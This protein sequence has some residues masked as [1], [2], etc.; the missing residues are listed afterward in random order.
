MPYG[1]QPPKF[2]QF[3]GKGNPKQH[4]AHFIETCNNAGTNGDLL[5]KRFVRSLKSTA[6]DWYTDLGSES[7]GSWDQ[8]ENEFVNHFYS[9]RRIV[10]MSELTNT[11]QW[12]DEPVIEYINRWRALS[13]ECKERL[14]E[15]YAVEM[16][17]NGM[18]WDL[19]YIFNGIKLRG[20]RVSNTRP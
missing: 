18:D 20:S 2:Q 19:L 10:S 16:C 8:L 4:I 9:T 6:F 17:I 3:D 13:L 1:Y 5:V 14:S 7:I 15:T 11:T 12:E